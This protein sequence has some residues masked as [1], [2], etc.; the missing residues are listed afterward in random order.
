MKK[1]IPVAF[2]LLFLKHLCFAGDI[3][4]KEAKI[5]PS[6]ISTGD[7]VRVSILF[8]GTVND[9]KEV[10]L[11][12]REYTEE[13]PWIPLEP[14][15][16]S[17]ENFWSETGIIPD[18]ASGLSFHLDINA[19]DKDGEEIVTQGFEDSATGKAGTIEVYVQ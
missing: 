3:V 7:T 11:T 10:Y 17:A 1:I 8:S 13:Y 6:V 5:E 4:L 16:T 19:V 9:L 2:V 18:D 12:V 14:D 15:T